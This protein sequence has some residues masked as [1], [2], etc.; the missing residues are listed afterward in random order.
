MKNLAKHNLESS[1]AVTILHDAWGAGP[2]NSS[3]PRWSGSSAAPNCFATMIQNRIVMVYE[4]QQGP[5][6]FGTGQNP[7][8]SES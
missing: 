4:E 5:V 3:A 8:T 7:V 6:D 2:S 1:S